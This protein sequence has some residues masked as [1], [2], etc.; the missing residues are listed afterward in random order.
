MIIS[1]IRIIKRCPKKNK[2]INKYNLETAID[3]LN[4]TIEINEDI[5]FNT[6]IDDDIDFKIIVEDIY[7]NNYDKINNFSKLQEYVQNDYES[8]IDEIKKIYNI[9][10]KDKIKKLNQKINR[11]N[12]FIDRIKNISAYDITKTL[13]TPSFFIKMRKK[14][15]QE[16]LKYIEEY[17]NEQFTH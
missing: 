15:F 8:Y 1:K 17:N 14:D 10:T 13:L 5:E 4:K 3:L 9:D 6:N 2:R 11:C 12:N 16:F 7:I